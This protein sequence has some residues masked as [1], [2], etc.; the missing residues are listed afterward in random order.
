MHILII[1][2]INKSVKL[3]NKIKIIDVIKIIIK[4]WLKLYNGLLNVSYYGVYLD[5]WIEQFTLLIVMLLLVINIYLNIN[6]YL[7]K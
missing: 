1:C 5:G 4:K 6:N 2:N 3:K 7:I